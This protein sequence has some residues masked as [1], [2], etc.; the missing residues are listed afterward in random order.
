M[1]QNICMYIYGIVINICTYMYDIVMD[2]D[3]HD[4]ATLMI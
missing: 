3:I 2:I 4:I 1:T